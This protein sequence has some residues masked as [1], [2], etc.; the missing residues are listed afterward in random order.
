MSIGKQSYLGLPWSLAPEY[1]TW[2]EKSLGFWAPIYSPH[3][4]WLFPRAISSLGSQ[5]LQLSISNCSHLRQPWGHYYLRYTI[6]G[7][8][9]RCGGAHGGSAHSCRP[10]C[11]QGASVTSKPFLITPVDFPSSVASHHLQMHFRNSQAQ[12]GS[13]MALTF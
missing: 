4:L 6:W 3:Y 12:R 7:I 9:Q 2:R 1:T 5:P 8:T 11:A 10:W 13:E